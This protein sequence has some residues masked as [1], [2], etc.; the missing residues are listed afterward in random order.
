MKFFIDFEATRFSNRIISI[1][2]VASNGATFSTLVNPNQKIDKFIME[3]TGITNVDLSKA[4]SADEAFNALFNFIEKNNDSLPPE[5]FCYG[6]S[7]AVFLKYT[8]RTMTETRACICAQAILGNL[9]DY[10][11]TVKQF[12]MVKSDMALRKVYMLIKSKNELVQRH[13]ALEDAVM[14]QAIVENLETKCKPED[15]DA[16]LAMPSQPKPNTKKA[17]AIFQE[18]DQAHVSKW[19]VN[20]KANASNWV[21]KCTDQHSGDIKYFDSI[22]TATLWVIKYA[23]RKVS[24]KNSKDINRVQETIQNAIN[25][26][27]CKYNFFW[28]F[29]TNTVINLMDGENND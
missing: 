1:G 24:P 25:S 21:V 11:T 13:D 12:F 7:D 18:W 20:T 2:C 15:K 14:L 6:D 16:I 19:D 17:P 23:A 8:I 26:K 4:P 29:N 27:K 5:Y 22:Y 10:A 3:L 28:E 9:V